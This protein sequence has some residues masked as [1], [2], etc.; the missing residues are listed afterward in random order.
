MRSQTLWDETK[1]L[2]TMSVLRMEARGFF[3]PRAMGVPKNEAHEKREKTPLGVFS[4]SKM[5]SASF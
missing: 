2:R 5:E 3:P 1:T 4:L